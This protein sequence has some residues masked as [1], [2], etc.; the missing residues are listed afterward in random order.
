MEYY[1]AIK[2]SD[3]SDPEKLSNKESLRGYA[4]ISLGKVDFTGGLGVG[5]IWNRR[6]Q[7]GG[8]VLGHTTGT[9]DIWG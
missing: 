3:C 7:L 9:G 1:S 4:R 2:D 5:G 8:K 6:D